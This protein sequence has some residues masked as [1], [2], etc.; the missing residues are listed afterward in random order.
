MMNFEQIRYEMFPILKK[1][2]YLNT[3]ANGLVSKKAIKS[4]EEWLKERE[5]GGVHWLEWYNEMNNLRE[6]IAKLINAQPSEIGFVQNT[7][8]GLNMVANSIQ[9]S[10]ESNIVTTD[11][12]FPANKY[13]WQVVSKKHG[14]ELR[15]IE[16]E[17][18]SLPIEKFEEAVDE[19]TRII[20]VSWVQYLNGYTIDLEKLSKIAKKHGAL[21]VVDGIQGVGSLRLDVKRTNIDF[22][23]VG[24]HKWLMGLHG[25]GFIYIKKELVRKLD[26]PF[27]G[28]LGTKEPFN[29]NKMYYEPSDDARIFEL[30]N[31]SFIGYR[32]LHESIKLINKIGIENIEKRNLQLAKYLLENKPAHAKVNEFLNTAEPS[33]PIINIEVKNV[34]NTYN[35]LLK[36][37]VIV[38]RRGKGLRVSIHFYNNEHDIDKLLRVL[39]DN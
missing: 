18:G 3:A 15:I 39:G 1:I 12:E 9:W 26:F 34:E 31:P 30:G 33:S 5:Y 24:G 16:N 21:L 35:K 20:A 23:A 38:A 2:T 8:V 37:G 36:T 4:G 19:N 6:E 7:T 13:V 28:W 14:T 22:I 11:M 27:A 17:D 29:F 32:V 10:E 25:S